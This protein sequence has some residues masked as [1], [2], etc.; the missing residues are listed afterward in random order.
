MTIARP[1]PGC[2]PG[3][4][5]APATIAG[6]ISLVLPL[7]DEGEDWWSRVAPLAGNFEIIAVDGGLVPAPVPPFPARVLVLPGMSRG[8][9][10][11]RGAR[12][13]GGSVL[14]FLHADSRPPADAR[15]RIERA[16]AA[17]A[18]AGCFL[19]RFDAETPALVRIARWANRRTR[20]ARLPFGDQGIICTLETYRR[21]G[22]FRDLP[23]CDDVDFVRRLRRLPG[24]AVLPAA[25]ETSS[26]RY[27]RPVRRVLRNAGVLAGYFAGVAP[28]K[29]ER[30]YRRDL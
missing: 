5:G 7:R 8:A 21:T 4:R 12:E 25:C 16:I 22:G 11:D 19:L 2:T 3:R 26:R 27:R 23:V 13:A 14:L 30:W 6:V 28:E 29:L 17:G 18:P 10:L 9:R 24:F 1:A 20:W 15:E